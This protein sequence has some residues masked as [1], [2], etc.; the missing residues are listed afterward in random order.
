MGAWAGPHLGCP[1]PLSAFMELPR[2]G[3]CWDTSS[4]NLLSSPG[5]VGHNLHDTVTT[6]RVS[7]PQSGKKISV[8]THVRPVFFLLLKSRPLFI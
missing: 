4:D 7:A 5:R 6:T 3:D 8:L 1:H 2:P